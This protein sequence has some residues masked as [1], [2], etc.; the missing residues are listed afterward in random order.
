MATHNISLQKTKDMRLLLLHYMLTWQ[1]EGGSDAT[2]KRAGPGVEGEKMGTVFLVTLA[3]DSHWLV[4]SN[5]VYEPMRES[6]AGTLALKGS[7]SSS[8]IQMQYKLHL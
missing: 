3:S 5:A 7:M 2:G 6:N 1:Q 8:L 4:R